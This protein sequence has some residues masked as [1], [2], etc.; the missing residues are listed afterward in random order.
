MRQLH[1]QSIDVP[2]RP[3]TRIYLQDDSQENNLGYSPSEKL[4][5]HVPLP[6][7]QLSPVSLL[8]LLLAAQVCSHSRFRED[9]NDGLQSP[10]YMH[11]ILKHQCI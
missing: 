3:F 10:A 4:S 9:F 11:F 6:K 5:G 8:K 1:S 7:T 2:N